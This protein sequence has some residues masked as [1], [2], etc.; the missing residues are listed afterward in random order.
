[1]YDIR[2]I[3]PRIGSNRRSIFNHNF[4]SSSGDNSGGRGRV[5]SKGSDVELSKQAEATSLTLGNF[6]IVP[7]VRQETPMRILS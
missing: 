6:S 7:V 4:L 3:N 1:M 2:Y 5:G